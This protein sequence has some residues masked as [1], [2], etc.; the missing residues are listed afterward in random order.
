[1][2]RQNALYQA[3]HCPPVSNV[4]QIVRPRYFAYF[5]LFLALDLAFVLALDSS[6]PAA[7]GAEVVSYYGYDDCI[8]LNNDS[9]SVVLCPSAGGRVLEYSHDGQNVLYL[10]PGDEGWRYGPQSQ[11]GTMNAGR[12]DIG[13]EKVVRRGKILWMGPWQGEI[14]GD[15]SARLTSEYDTESGAR[16]VRE[17]ELDESTS[18]LRCTQTIINESERRVS[19]CHWSRTFAVGGGIAVIPR[20]PRGRFPRGYVMYEQGNTVSFQPEDPSIQVSD[21]AVIVSAAPEF[22]KLGF[23]SHAGWL[24]YLAPTNQMFVK[25]FRT[26]PHRAYNELAALTISVWYP[27]QDRVELEPIGPA[28]DLAPGQRA[29]FTEE[30]WLLPHDFP[31][32]SEE[33]SY[34]AIEKKV[35]QDTK[36]GRQD[37][38]SIASPEVHSDRRVTFRFVGN[39]AGEVR[40]VLA[41]KSRT[42]DQDSNGVWSHTSQ[43]LQPGIY[44]YTFE[45]DGVR[46][47]DPRN[48]WTKKWLTC[49]SMFEVPGDPPL[50]TEQQAVPHGAVHRHLYRSET[51][52]TDRAAVVYTPPG[53]DADAESPY[54]V[55]VLCHGFGDDETAWTEVGRAH[56]IV[57]NLLSSGAIEPM[58]I[59]MP[60]GHPVPLQTRSWSE[61]YGDDNNVAMVRDVVNDLLPFV[62]HNYNVTS[63]QQQR[64]VVGLSMGGG[65]SIRIGMLHPEKFSWVGALSA[66]TPQGDLADSQPALIE[67]VESG[68]R[69]RKLFWIACGTDDFLIERNRGFNEQLNQHGIKHTYVETQGSHN[70]NVWRDYLPQFLQLVYQ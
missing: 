34:A 35:L 44:D 14:T 31:Q 41:G 69:G 9:V 22:P 8:Q 50:V 20:S 38:R 11:R 56:H 28:E 67:N 51:T 46:V 52:G 33:L 45:V 62:E 36:G 63:D 37:L 65:H 61:N 39:E 13:P 32:R 47:T 4:S 16:L 19:L 2:D 55:V 54:P 5:A 25:R 49:A 43:P 68:I 21:E 27:E 57:D 42:L 10:P 66:S 23:D 53:Y 60:H 30:W 18:R 26:F 40:L 1:L 70:W 7:E 29:S 59:V 48:R 3:P 58:V 17:F 64:A 24:A 12:F 15:R 6:L